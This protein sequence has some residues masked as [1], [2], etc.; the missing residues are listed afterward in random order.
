MIV[1]LLNVDER[2]ANDQIR[3]VYIE[4]VLEPRCIVD[5][6]RDVREGASGRLQIRKR[7]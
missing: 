5:E 1:K 3:L 7:W 6:L 4:A 2:G